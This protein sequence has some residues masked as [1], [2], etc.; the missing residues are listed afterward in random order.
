MK[1]R[2]SNAIKA[3]ARSKEVDL[4]TPGDAAPRVHVRFAAKDGSW[5]GVAR[6]AVSADPS[7]KKALGESY[8][9]R[10]RG[11]TTI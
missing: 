3:L 5:Q 11:Q 1:L 6:F 4:E 8:L 9:L 10:N 7:R 2:Y